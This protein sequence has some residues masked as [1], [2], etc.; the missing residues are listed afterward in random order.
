MVE[1]QDKN[2]RW[3]HNQHGGKKVNSGTFFI[4]GMPKDFSWFS[5]L[6]EVL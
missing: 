2:G 5:S 4:D 3:I 1:V 6:E